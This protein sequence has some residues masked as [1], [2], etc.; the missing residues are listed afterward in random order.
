VRESKQ[1]LEWQAEAKVETRR[2]D[3]L[4]VLEALC[5]SK[6]P[7]DVVTLIA[8]CA[9]PGQLSRWLDVALKVRSYDEFRA[10]ISS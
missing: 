7:A 3:L 8:A 5:G 9:D 2:V 6:T 10:M 4:R 1:V